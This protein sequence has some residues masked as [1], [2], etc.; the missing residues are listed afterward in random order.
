MIFT[1]ITSVVAW[2]VLVDSVLRIITGLAIATELLGRTRTRC[3]DT[4]ARRRAL[5][6]S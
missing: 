4:A 2:L 5:E 6:Q 3:A 1:K